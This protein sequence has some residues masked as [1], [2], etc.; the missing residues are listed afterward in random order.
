MRDWI[1]EE[2]AARDAGT[3][4]PLSQSQHRAVNSR[5]PGCTV[6]RCEYCGTEIDDS[7]THC[8]DCDPQVD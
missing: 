5:Y 4:R 2:K 8:D 6:K 3:S 1:D 7:Q